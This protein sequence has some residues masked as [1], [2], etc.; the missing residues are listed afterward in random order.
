MTPPA[1]PLAQAIHEA[2]DWYAR[3][4]GQTVTPT[5]EH[6]WRTWL[7]NSEF[8]QQAWQKVETVCGRFERVPGRLGLPTLTRRETRRAVVRSLILCALLGGGGTVAYRNAPWR[9]WTSDLRTS[10]GERRNMQLADGSQLILNARTALNVQFDAAHRTLHLLA[11]EILVTTHADSHSPARPFRVRTEQGWIRALGTRF[12]VRSED[13]RTTVSVLEKAVD[14]SP[15]G[16]PDLHQ[17]VEAGQRFSF[18]HD[19][20]DGV[21]TIRPGSDA[22]ADGRLVVVDRPLSEVLAELSRYRSGHV[23]CSPDVASLRVSGAFPL[24]DS[25]EALAALADSFLLRI[26]YRTRYWVRVLPRAG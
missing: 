12:M 8:N 14:A 1:D 15:H 6:A 18:A 10:T 19:S 25:D 13:G 5:L 11:G 24:D 2:A 16:L 7:A 22:W 9:E 26:E 20:S 17:R 3:L 23:A 4:R 21:D